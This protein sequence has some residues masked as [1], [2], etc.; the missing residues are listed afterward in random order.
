MSYY[1]I[2]QS[3]V[4]YSSFWNKD[5]ERLLYKTENNE[6]MKTG[7]LVAKSSIEPL[8]ISETNKYSQNLE[9]S[10]TKFEGN[11]RITKIE[12]REKPL[13]STWSTFHWI[14]SEYYTI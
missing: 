9:L 10:V 2:N 5:G 8:I 6:I 1:I 4:Y 3:S 14:L 12:K 13:P 11:S 7:S